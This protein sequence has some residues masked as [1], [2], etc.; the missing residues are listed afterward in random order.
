MKKIFALL[1]ILAG[2]VA[3]AQV[4]NNEW[5]DYSKTYYKFKIGKTGLYRVT[6]A[7]L[8]GAGL[9]SAPAEQFQLWRN[10]VQVPLFTSVSQGGFSSTDYIEFWGELNDGKADKPLYRNPDYQLNDKWSL[11]T[12]TAAYFLT[13]NQGLNLRLTNTPNDV[14]GNTLA[15]EPYFTHTAGMYYKEKI[16]A[17]YAVPV[18]ENLYSSSYDKGEGYTSADIGKGAIKNAT[19]ANLFTYTA[20]PAAATFKIAASGNGHNAR[21]Y[22]V[23]I[24][25]TTI[26]TANSLDYY[27]YQRD[28]VSIPVSILASNSALVS[29]TN[30]GVIANDRMVIHQFEL[31]YPRKFN[32]GDATNFEFSL[33]ASAGNYLEIAGFKFGAAAPVLYDITNGKRYTAELSG[34]T[35]KIVLQSSAEERKLVLVSQEATN[36]QNVSALQSRTFINYALSENAGNYIIISHPV[37]FN[38]PGGTNPV[39]EYRLYRSSAEG[40]SYAA[41]TYIADDLVD[42]FAFGI[43]KH[44]LSIRN[45][46]QFAREQFPVAPKQ[47]FLIGKGIQYVHQ[48]QYENNPDIER[49]N[50]VPTFGNPASDIMLS[51]NP[52]DSYPQIPIGRLSVISGDEIATY[53]KK[54]K[55]HELAQRTPS[56]L[57]SEKAWMKN[58]VHIVGASEPVLQAML[59]GYMTKYKGIIEDTLFGAKVTTFTKTSANSVEQIN[60][61]L[62]D[63]LFEEGI[64]LMTYFGHSSSGTL[65]FNLNNPA[66]YNNHGKYPMFIALGCNAG[67]FY[68]FATDR[69]QVKETL[70]E[71]YVLAPERGTIGFIAS[72][73]FGIPHY[74]DIFTTQQYKSIAYKDYGKTIGEIMQSTIRQVYDAKT[75]EDFYARA[76]AEETSLHGDPAITLNPHPKPDYVIE[77]ALVKVAPSFISVADPF[78]NVKA[79]FLNIGKAVNQPIVCEVKREYPNGNTEIIYRDTI[80]GIRYADSVSI[81]IAIDALRDK[82]I[83]KITVTIDAGNDVDEIF[84]TNNSITKEVVIYEDE[85]RP[86]YPYNFSIINKQNIRFYASTANPLSAVQNYR[87]EIDTTERFNSSLLKSDIVVSSGGVVEFSPSINFMDS[88]VYYWRVAK[89]SGSIV[90]KWNTNSFIYKSNSEAGFSQSHYFQHQKSTSQNLYLDTLNRLWKYNLIPHNLFA[91]NAMYPTSGTQDGD[92]SVAIDGDPYMRSACVGRSLIFNVFDGQTFEPWKNVDGNGKNLFLSGSGSANCKPSRNWNFEFSFM[93]ASS[94]K[95][96]MNFMDSIPLGS[97]VVIRSTD[98]NNPGSFSATWRGDTSLYG[99]NNS[100]YHRLLNAGFI[101]I[102]SLNSPRDWIMIYQKGNIQLQPKY[103]ISKG[104]YD[105]ITLSAD[106]FVSGNNGKISSPLIGPAQEWKRLFWAGYTTDSKLGDNATLSLIGIKVNG[107]ADTLLAKVESTQEGIDVSFINAA[108]YPYLRLQMNNVDTINHTPYQLDYWRVTYKSEPEGA[109]A[110]NILF[111][112]KDTLELG[113]PIDFKLAFKNISDAGFDSLKVKM[114][115]TDKN[116]VTHVLPIQKFKPL[117]ANDTVHVRYPIDTRQ[118]AGLNALYIEVNP[119]NDQPEQYHFNNFLYKNFYVIADTLNPL[120]D[121]TFDNVHILNGDIVSAKPD[122]LITLQDEAKWKLLDDTALVSVQLKYPDGSS[123]AYRYDSDTLRFLPP[124]SPGMAGNTAVINFKPYLPQDGD[125]ELTVRGRDRSENQAGN[126]EYKVR[127]EVINKAMISNMLNY[128]NPFTTSTA[129]VFTITGAEVPQN[130]K[131]EILTVTGKIVREITKE[132]LGPLRI[133]R[134]ITE[135]KWNG[136]DQYGQ[137]LANGVYIYRVVTNLNGKSLERYRSKTDDTDKYFN[138][139]YGKMYLMR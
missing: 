18:G 56:P 109:V 77:D 121:V 84:E 36:V 72:S 136:T 132:E 1:F 41:K 107:K 3:K 131:I 120:L 63:R 71:K 19:F 137:K 27:N 105:K 68:N 17:G 90:E 48:R 26:I 2:F 47:V 123:R 116:N 117:A 88:T 43:K 20:G 138:K 112:M 99:V 73:H 113:E 89:V 22:K 46:L 103:A 94:R 108:V 10:G 91:R 44:P 29:I 53:L 61:G 87:F 133:G 92:F 79:K 45:F 16:N 110:P 12:D 7:T 125:Y 49:L 38:S 101:Q 82:G 60:N 102:D 31:Q 67:N 23:S 35:V 58:V 93:S 24:N 124:Q 100:L 81:D 130:F 33:P 97:Y 40:G 78:F 64:T 55:E 39:E 135:F 42:Q 11:Q 9:G 119:D 66:Q 70:S 114:V 126:L 134:N 30:L 75:Q 74:L 54:V 98:Y 111:T 69:F 52:R 50:L 25:N 128:P 51:A 8:Q 139:G 5:I 118:L 13:L 129:F 122:I 86:V 76:N 85:I 115:I 21:E 14:A 83:N 80:P 15:P 59:D 57:I 32:F 65:E 37:L 95:N 104:L 4:Y 28:S 96:I 62:L 106:C 34:T 127:F 6:Q